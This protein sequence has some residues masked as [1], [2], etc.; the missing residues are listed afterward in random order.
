MAGPDETETV[1]SDAEESAR[2]ARRGYDYQDHT[3]AGFCLQM[4]PRFVH[5]LHYS[6][7]WPCR[8]VG[9][10]G[11]SDE[12]SAMR[13]WWVSYYCEPVGSAGEAGVDFALGERT[14]FFTTAHEDRLMEKVR[15]IRPNASPWSW[16]QTGVLNLH[17]SHPA[18]V[19]VRNWLLSD[20]SN[21]GWDP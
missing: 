5:E 21:A 8:L 12:R 1:I 9:V 15:K 20:L 4:L 19:L 3:A 14:D 13:S 2:R 16:A 11:Q 17:D 18:T 6:A 10:V 7:W